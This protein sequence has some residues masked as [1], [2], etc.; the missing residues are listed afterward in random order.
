MNIEVVDEEVED[1]N[2]TQSVGMENLEH[3]DNWEVRWEKGLWK[4][5]WKSKAKSIFERLTFK[6][7]Q[8]DESITTVKR[9]DVLVE[10]G[11]NSKV[12]GEGPKL[13]ETLE[14]REQTASAARGVCPGEKRNQSKA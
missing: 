14:I 8:W 12:R 2:N 7:F 9:E 4:R 13:E 10:R 5:Q 11:I 3:T 1:K 6:E